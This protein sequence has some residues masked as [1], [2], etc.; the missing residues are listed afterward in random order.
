MHK[1]LRTLVLAVAV[2]AVLTPVAFGGG[3]PA[4]PQDRKFSI[5]LDGQGAGGCTTFWHSSHGMCEVKA[6]DWF[7]GEPANGL[8]GTN[9]QMRWCEHGGH[10]T[11]CTERLHHN[12]ANI[13]VTWPHGYTRWVLIC[14]SVICP[15][16]VIGAT[17][18]ENGPFVVLAGR[19]DGHPIRAT[20][21]DPTKVEHN[22]GPLLLQ[23]VYKGDAA[24]YHLPFHYVF[25]LRGWI[26]W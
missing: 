16:W 5:H 22:G 6:G 24:R 25:G 8:Q 9:V 23:H 12:G 10:A 4:A 21:S 20:G 18:G 7:R 13:H 15:N 17:R 1:S 11:N 26:H 19:I 3:V 14:R 2:L